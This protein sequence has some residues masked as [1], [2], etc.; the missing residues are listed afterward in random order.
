MGQAHDDTVVAAGGHCQGLGVDL[1]HQ[2]MVA[3]RRKRAWQPREQG[4]AVMMDGA[5][6]S[7]PGDRGAR[8][9]RP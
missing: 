6:F 7:V 4:L 2:G 1:H 8:T 9:V 5:H 3:G